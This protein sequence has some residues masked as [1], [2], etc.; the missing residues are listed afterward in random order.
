MKGTG[1][2]GG[3]SI[4]AAGTSTAREDGEGEHVDNRSHIDEYIYADPLANLL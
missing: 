1:E 4:G 3:S 2:T